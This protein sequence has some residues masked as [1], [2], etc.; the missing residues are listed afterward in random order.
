M[1]EKEFV[2]GKRNGK[3]KEFYQGKL[4]FEGEYLNGERLKGK[5]Y[6]NENTFRNFR[7]L[8]IRKK[9]KKLKYKYKELL[10]D[11]ITKIENGK[12]KNDIYDERLCFEGEYLYGLR[13][14]KG[15]EYFN[16]ILVFE[17]EFS[18]GHR[19][20]QIELNKIDENVK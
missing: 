5:E 19:V 2:N 8:A 16:G 6:F 9:I 11:Y 12:S 1:F 14:G 15:K 10:S 20:E 13:N 17:G 3:G 7:E 18:L 4:I